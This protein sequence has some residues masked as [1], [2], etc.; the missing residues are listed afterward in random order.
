MTIEEKDEILRNFIIDNPSFIQDDLPVLAFT[1]DDFHK[2]MNEN[3]CQHCQM[4]L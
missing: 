3:L 1:S 2:Y 4:E